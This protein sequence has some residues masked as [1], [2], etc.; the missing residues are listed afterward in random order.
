MKKL[1]DF[2]EWGANN[3]VVFYLIILPIGMG[4]V[5]PIILLLPFL[6]LMAIHYIATHFFG[7]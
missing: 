1:D 3:E 6:P 5:A 4:V 2:F 7:L